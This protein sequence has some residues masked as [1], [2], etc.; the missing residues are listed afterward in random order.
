MKTVLWIKC[1]LDFMNICK[2]YKLTDAIYIIYFLSNDSNLTIWNCIYENVFTFV[3]ENLVYKEIFA[4]F[5][6]HF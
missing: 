3:L 2:V 5:N 4:F 6:L 1:L